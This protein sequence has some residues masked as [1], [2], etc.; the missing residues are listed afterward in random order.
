MSK[1]VLGAV[2]EA[3]GAL[4]RPASLEGALHATDLARWPCHG[5]TAQVLLAR[6]EDIRVS[7]NWGSGFMDFAAEAVWVWDLACLGVGCLGFRG[8]VV[9]CKRPVML[10]LFRNEH[11]GKRCRFELAR[12]PVVILLTCRTLLPCE[13]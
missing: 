1:R 2:M 6:F 13:N 5:C 11:G 9:G 10:F 4:R 12:G 8:F 3:L 7:S